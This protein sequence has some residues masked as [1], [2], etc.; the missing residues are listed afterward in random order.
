MYLSLLFIALCNVQLHVHV[1]LL[2][3]KFTSSTYYFSNGM[4][5][6][7]YH[8]IV[9]VQKIII[10]WKVYYIN[11]LYKAAMLDENKTWRTPTLKIEIS[12]AW[13]MLYLRSDLG[14][15]NLKSK[16]LFVVR[17]QIASTYIMNESV[18]ASCVSVKSSTLTTHNLYRYIKVRLYN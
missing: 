12:H 8:H 9:R 5:V 3:L 11:V 14:S 16:I 4:S 2:I 15:T 17:L 18:H 6:L 13:F 7:F 10:M 1:H